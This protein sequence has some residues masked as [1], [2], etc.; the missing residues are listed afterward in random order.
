MAST[1]LTFNS[2]MLFCCSPK[3]LLKSKSWY[4]LLS[5]NLLPY[6]TPVGSCIKSRREFDW[7]R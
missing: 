5:R 2:P 3:L 1:Y 4:P 6:L 7:T